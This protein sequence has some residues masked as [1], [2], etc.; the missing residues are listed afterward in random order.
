M[1]SLEKGASTEDLPLSGAG[2]TALQLRSLVSLP[3]DRGS[4]PSTYMAAPV[5][6]VPGDPMLSSALLMY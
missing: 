1:V 4:N 6:L 2:E 5:T 3:E